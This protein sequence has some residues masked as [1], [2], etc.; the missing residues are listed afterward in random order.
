MLQN[1]KTLS[2]H[3]DA[4]WKGDFTHNGTML[5]LHENGYTIGYS[6]LLVPAGTSAGTVKFGDG[7]FFDANEGNNKA[8]VGAPTTLG[9]VPVFAGIVVRE[10]AIASGYPVLNDEI[11]AFQK[12]LLCR[13]GY[14]IYK[15]GNVC[16]AS[17]AMVEDTAL[18]GKVYPNMCMWVN[19][20]NG[21]VYFSAKSSV[22][23]QAGDIN[24][25]RVVEVNPDDESITVFVTPSITADTT[26]ITS[27]TPTVTV[28]TAT[29]TEIPLTISAK[30][31]NAL[32]V[33]YK[34]TA[35]DDYTSFGTVIPTLNSAGTAYEASAVIADLI[36]STEYTVKV[37]V[38]TAFGYLSA[39]AT[40]T[41]EA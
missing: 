23:F 30:T 1:G 31:A 14:I 18:Y 28:G 38:Y 6:A 35:D 33:S 10:P 25:G 19:K 13:E 36:A 7:V 41:T 17:G 15:H 20:T 12:G 29:S 21:E 34:K 8:Y 11:S 9:A 22:Y 39:T 32:V 27:A 16:T 4:I 5:K 2:M 3:N 37:E 26:E 24:I 40:G